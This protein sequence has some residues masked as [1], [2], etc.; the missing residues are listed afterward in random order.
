MRFSFLSIVGAVMLASPLAAMAQVEIVSCSIS[1]GGSATNGRFT[2]VCSITQPA[3]G[4]PLS[5][6]RFVFVPGFLAPVAAAPS[7][8]CR[9]DFNNSGS[10]D[11]DDIADYIGA[12][13]SQ[14]PAAGSDFNGDG[15]VD[16]DDLAD[17][18]GAYFAG[19]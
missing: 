7:A 6:G 18:L 8:P 16:P 13:F 14:P 4:Q 9:G 10:L 19:C 3:S 12:F 5:G 2:A 1:S 15:F 11:P 17:Y